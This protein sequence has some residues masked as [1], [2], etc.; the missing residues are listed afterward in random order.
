MSKSK[1]MNFVDEL[2]HRIGDE[3]VAIA[4]SA[5]R[6]YGAHTLPGPDR[7]TRRQR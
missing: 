6:S 4:E 7:P 1:V 3:N 5:L 2:K